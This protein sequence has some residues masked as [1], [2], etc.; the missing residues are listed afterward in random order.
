[1]YI[2]SIFR[3]IYSSDSIYTVWSSI[4]KLFCPI[5]RRGSRGRSRSWRDSIPR[6]PTYSI[7]VPSYSRE[8]PAHEQLARPLVAELERCI[9]WIRR[10]YTGCSSRFIRRKCYRHRRK[11]NLQTPH[12]WG[13]FLQMILLLTSRSFTHFTFSKYSPLFCGRWMSTTTTQLVSFSSA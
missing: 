11:A 12:R 7:C 3:V 2:E 8:I 1:M 5:D 10:G 6:L 9:R 13:S 4:V